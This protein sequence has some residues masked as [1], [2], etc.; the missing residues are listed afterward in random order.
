MSPKNG[1]APL[2][3]GFAERRSLWATVGGGSLSE[4]PATLA[5]GLQPPGHT[6]P[7]APSHPRPPATLVSLVPQW[8][9]I[10]YKPWSP[11]M[12]VMPVAHPG[13]CMFLACPSHGLPASETAPPPPHTHSRTPHQPS[14]RVS[15]TR[16]PPP[17]LLAHPPRLL[18]ASLLGPIPGGRLPSSYTDG[19]FSHL[20]PQTRQSSKRIRAARVPGRRSGSAGHCQG[21]QSLPG[22][23]HGGFVTACSCRGPQSLT[24]GE[25]ALK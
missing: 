10:T 17:Q 25:C 16:L 19:P 20:S 23:C 7:P 11:D 21:A 12:Y 24:P 5:L 6:A 8:A 1:K 13:V 14:R 9:V 18:R 2:E 4:G 22:H 3:R 15:R